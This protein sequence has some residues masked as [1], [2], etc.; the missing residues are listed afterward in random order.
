MNIE[1]LYSIVDRDGIQVCEAAIRNK[2]G[3]CLC[4]NSKNYIVLNKKLISSTTEEKQVVAEEYGHIHENALYI[5]NDYKNPCRNLNI[6]RAEQRA[7]DKSA[8][9]LVP[10]EELKKISAI[11]TEIYQLAEYFDVTEE[12]VLNAISYYKRKNLL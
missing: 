10:L 4:L 5:Y 12:I 11:Y 3:V 9:T 8:S 7:K 2:A 6:Q 1:T